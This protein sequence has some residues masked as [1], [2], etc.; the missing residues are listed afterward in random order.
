VPFT[1]HRN[2]ILPI[3][4]PLQTRHGGG[5]CIESTAHPRLPRSS[6]AAPMPSQPADV[7]T[8]SV[9]TSDDGPYV[10]ARIIHWARWIA[11]HA[12]TWISLALY[13]TRDSGA[14]T[15]C[16]IAG[17]C[18]IAPKSIPPMSG[19]AGAAACDTSAYGDPVS[20]HT[21]ISDTITV[22]AHTV[23]YGPVSQNPITL[24]GTTTKGHARGGPLLTGWSI[25]V[26]FSTSLWAAG[27][28][29]RPCGAVQCSAVQDAT[30]AKCYVTSH[31]V[32][33]R[34]CGAGLGDRALVTLRLL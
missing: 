5:L 22:A 13:A 29:V 25:L 27:L 17:F 15:I 33:A 32:A 12:I 26:A 11:V 21:A 34:C 28:S 18:I 1:V 6:S 24:R 10:C 9:A 16:I 3:A 7:S 19:I 2:V 30:A 14:L 23:V 20:Y 8:R 4:Q 31:T